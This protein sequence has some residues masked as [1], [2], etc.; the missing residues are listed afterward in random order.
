MLLGAGSAPPM[1]QSEERSR[2]QAMT[3]IRKFAL[4]PLPLLLPHTG[5]GGPRGRKRNQNALEWDALGC[6][7]Q[8]QPLYVSTVLSC[9]AFGFGFLMLDLMIAYFTLDYGDALRFFVGKI[10]NVYRPP[11]V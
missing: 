9:V 8:C 11:I 5:D 1:P 10:R 3:K 2:P 6:F 4:W 7:L